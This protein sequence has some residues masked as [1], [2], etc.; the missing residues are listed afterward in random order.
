[1]RYSLRLLWVLLRVNLQMAL[2]YRADLAVNLL[3][4]LVTLGWELLG[5][6]IIFSNTQ[7]L[8]GWNVG[9]LVALLGVFRLVNLFMSALIFPNANEFMSSVRDGAFDFVLLK[10]L[11]SLFLVSFSRLEFG[12]VGDL[13]LAGILIGSG[14]HLSEM[15]IQPWQWAAFLIL[16]C[17]GALVIYS[18]CV[19]MLS[20]TF[21]FIK[22]DNS[23]TIF[24]ALLDTGRYPSTIY[25]NWLRVVV[26][27]I[28]P[29]ALAVTVPMQALIGAFS[30]WQVLGYFCLGMATFAAA[31]LIWKAGVKKYSGASS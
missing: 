3:M 11:P 14:I 31:L 29:I 24:S 5:L 8:G 13:L 17:S 25:P 15:S 20:M 19:V 26:T 2:A 28:I 23:M 30:G 22:F 1:M 4:N 12:Q 27:F 16:V 21:W 10:P 18:L 7:A 6:T 9:Q